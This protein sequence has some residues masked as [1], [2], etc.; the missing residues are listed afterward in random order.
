M[1]P[2]HTGMGSPS[3]A[4]EDFEKCQKKMIKLMKE[5]KVEC[6][7]CKASCVTIK[8]LGM[9]PLFSGIEPIGFKTTGKVMKCAKC[10]YVYCSSTKVEKLFFDS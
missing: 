1:I 5:G 4:K 9:E 8:N 3:M 6:P 10:G 2:E 7:D